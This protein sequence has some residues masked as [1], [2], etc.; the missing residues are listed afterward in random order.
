MRV[1]ACISDF[2]M[3]FGAPPGYTYKITEY[4]SLMVKFVGELMSRFSCAT[5]ATTAITTPSTIIT[6]LLILSCSI[7][8]LFLC[9]Y[10]FSQ[11]RLITRSHDHSSSASLPVNFSIF[12]P[13][14]LP[15]PPSPN[16]STSTNLCRHQPLLLRRVR[17][18]NHC[19]SRT[20]NIMSDTAIQDAPDEQGILSADN[21]YVRELMDV[22]LKEA[23]RI[24]NK[25]SEHSA[26]E[27]LSAAGFY[28]LGELPRLQSRKPNAWNLFLRLEKD[29]APE[30]LRQQK[31]GVAY[32]KS[33][34]GLKG[35]YQQYMKQRWDTEPELRKKYERLAKG[36]RATAS[37]NDGES[38]SAQEN[39]DEEPEVELKS[40]KQIQKKSLKTLKK[41]VRPILQYL[42]VYRCIC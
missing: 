9:R 10:L 5:S 39:I 14:Y 4:H 2:L 7:T 34:P 31:E 21:I 3:I 28:V 22:V 15:I 19:I 42:S 17:S 36:S 18:T 1:H 29:N 33:R 25:S 23:A 13:V 11:P 40:H 27:L 24:A 38:D 30:A 8:R 35:D 20:S 12:Q 41:H 16:L 32:N 37:V 6:R 26:D